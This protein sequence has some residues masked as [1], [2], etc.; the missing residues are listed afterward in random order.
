MLTAQLNLLQAAYICPCKP[1]YPSPPHPHLAAYHTTLLA[2]SEGQLAVAGLSTAAEQAGAQLLAAALDQHFAADGP[3]TTTEDVLAIVVHLLKAARLLMRRDAQQQLRQAMAALSAGRPEGLPPF[4]LQQAQY[5][6]LNHAV[7]S[8]T[9]A[10]ARCTSEEQLQALVQRPDVMEA[11]AAATRAVSILEQLEPNSPATVAHASLLHQ[12]AMLQSRPSSQA[13]VQRLLRAAR[14][15][16]AQRSDYW[17]IRLTAAA[18]MTCM[19]VQDAPAAVVQAAVQRLEGIDAALARCKRLLPQPWVIMLQS[20]IAMAR[21]M[22]PLVHARLASLLAR[23]SG[24]P[25]AAAAARSLADQTLRAASAAVSE[26]TA[27]VMPDYTC[28]GCGKRA[29]G[30]RACARCRAAYYCSVQCQRVHWPQHKRECRP[31]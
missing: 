7:G 10:T 28:A 16:Q 22:L 25:A 18:A 4:L 29:V 23:E 12:A 30:L 13:D 17:D 5:A 27:C 21:D 26:G 15:A 19:G 3:A 6:C 1:A 2:I 31:A 9:A 14:R 11:Q 20:G 8:V 24:D